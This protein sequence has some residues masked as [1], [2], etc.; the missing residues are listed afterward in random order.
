[1]TKLASQ[2]LC[3]GQ[4]ARATVARAQSDSEHILLIY[5]VLFLKTLC[6]SMCPILWFLFGNVEKI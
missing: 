6:L 5:V 1:M 3:V 2:K 4:R